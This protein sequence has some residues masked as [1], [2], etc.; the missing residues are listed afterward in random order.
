VDKKKLKNKDAND[1]TFLE[2]LEV[3][4]GHLLRSVASIGVF[5]VIVFVFKKIII[6]MI[7]LAPKSVDFFTNRM[8]CKFGQWI[9]T[10]KLCIN[11]LPIQLINIEMAGQFRIHITIAL[12]GGMILAAPYIFW[13]LYRFIMPALKDGERKYSSGMV[14]F[15]SLL[16]MA[17]ILFGYFMIVP[18]TLNFLGT[19]SVSAEVLNQ[20]NLKSYIGTITSLIFATGLVF[21]MPILVYF[22]SK[23]GI[24]TPA[25][26]R[27]YRKHALI[28][29]LVLSGIITPPDIFSQIMV[30]IPMYLLYEI[31]ILI[32]ARI[33]KQ[34]EEREAADA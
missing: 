31:S 17:G 15:T 10:D 23:V 11:E 12:Y 9:N 27:R 1:M 13:E 5:A 3:L 19:Y 6:D 33:E 25:F 26:M 20:I 8:L 32:S 18:L 2:H 34:R 28:I 4:R 24:M 22:L 7:L 21:E 14:F 16:F 30:A 29:I